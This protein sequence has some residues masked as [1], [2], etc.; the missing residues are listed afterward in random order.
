L[1]KELLMSGGAEFGQL[2][3]NLTMVF[4]AAKVGG[5]LA[6]RLRQPAVLGELAAGLVVGVSGLQWLHPDQQV[7][8][9]MAQI[10][11]TLLLFEIGLESDLRALLKVGWQSLLVGI[12]GMVAPFGLGMAVMLPQP[13]LCTAARGIGVRAVWAP[14]AVEALN[15]TLLQKTQSRIR[16]S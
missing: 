9:L 13:A 12:I 10:G 5:E 4:M 11:V 7:L 14:F 1:I 15:C 2:L 6:L 16:L 8:Q 3:A